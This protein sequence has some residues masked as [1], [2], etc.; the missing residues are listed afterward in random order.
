MRIANA[1]CSWGMLE[2]EGV[3]KS[4]IGYHTMLDELVEAGYAGTE[5]GDWGYMPTDSALLH[6]EL[7]TRGVSMR[8][9][10]VPVALRS[11]KV[12]KAGI[13]QAVR[14]AT[15]LAE[16]ATE[17]DPPFLVLADENAADV[18]RTAQAGRITPDM[19]LTDEEWSTFCSNA[20][21]VAT[22]VQK[23]S[24]LGTVFHH[25]CA[26]FVE[27]PAELDI[28]L[29]RTDPNLIGLLLDTGHYA[30]GAGSCEAVLE[31]LG[32]HYDRICYVHYKDCHPGVA[33]TARRRSWDYFS[34]VRN[35][36][37]CEL[38]RGCVDFEGITRFLRDRAYNGWIVVEQDVLPGMGSPRRSAMRNRAYLRSLGL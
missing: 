18:V 5:L 7:V 28:F 4:Q 3:A 31:A 24:G 30:Y 13:E 15:L 19:A 37:F 20:E 16:V 2:F 21:A 10:F 25:H 17:D 26:G 23:E 35:G 6:E 34:A 33:A 38:G 32:N 29:K 1:P 27:T 36:V 14:V 12:P 8:G 11:P 22:A 9:A